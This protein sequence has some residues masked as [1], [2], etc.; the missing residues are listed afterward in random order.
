MKNKL[1]TLLL[2][3]VTITFTHCQR[4]EANESLALQA[5]LT[6]EPVS[7]NE[8]KNLFE[9]TQAK[10]G[11]ILDKHKPLRESF[12]PKSLLLL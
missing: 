4:E 6:N 2:V 12:I 7:F 8:A 10:S 1:K 3:A 5:T 11:I 9:A